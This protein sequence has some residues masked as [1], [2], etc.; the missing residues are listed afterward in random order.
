M[1]DFS[2]FENK[3]N[4]S[5]FGTTRMRI[6]INHKLITVLYKLIAVFFQLVAAVFVGFFFKLKTG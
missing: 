4:L 1:M 5:Y 3:D 2:R 6:N